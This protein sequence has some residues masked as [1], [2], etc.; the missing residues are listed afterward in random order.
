MTTRQLTD[1]EKA[2]AVRDYAAQTNGTDSYHRIGLS[3][4]MATDGAH[5]LAEVCG[6]HWLLDLIAS[7]QPDILRKHG[8]EAGAFQVWKLDALGDCGVRVTAEDGDRGAGPVV[9]AEQEVP[10]SDF[11]RE[12]LPCQL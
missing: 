2:Q 1:A 5:L 7:H 9:L 12:L 3:R 8:Q 11:P 6:A 4:L 10:Y